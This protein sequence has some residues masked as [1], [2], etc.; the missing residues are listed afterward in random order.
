MRSLWEYLTL[1]DLAGRI[2]RPDRRGTLDPQA[3]P[4]LR[5]LGSDE[6]RWRHQVFGIETRYWRAVGLVDALL[7]KAK[8]LGQRWLKGSGAIALNAAF[9]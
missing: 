2:A 6:S 3:V 8:Q 4:L 5:R 1:I 7:D 9:R